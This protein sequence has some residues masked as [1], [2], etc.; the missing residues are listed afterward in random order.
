MN[1]RKKGRCKKGNSWITDII[2]R[3]IKYNSNEE[4]MKNVK[5]LI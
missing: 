5:D 2:R 3:G 1:V 4:A